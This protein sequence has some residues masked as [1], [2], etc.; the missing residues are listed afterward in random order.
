MVIRFF[1]NG[2]VVNADVT[3]D[4]MLL[5]LLREKMSMLSVR[6][7]CENGEC[8]ACTVLLDDKPVN[9]CLIP[10]ARVDGHRITTLEGLANDPF[11]LRLQEAFVRHGALQCGFCGSGMLIS[12]FSLLRDDSIIPSQET[13]REGIAG[14][15]CRCTGYVKIIEA[16]LDV[17]VGLKKEAGNE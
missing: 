2:A 15:L 4:E 16:I 1:L 12:A 17:A 9:S 11:M 3:P 8:G 10:A 14:N 7:G 6:R 13:V 5:A